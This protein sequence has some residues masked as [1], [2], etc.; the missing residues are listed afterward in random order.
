MFAEK[1]L[2]T[3]FGLGQFCDPKFIEMIGTV[4]GW[5]AVWLDQEHA[6]L[7]IEQISHAARAAKVV[8]LDCFVRLAPTDYAT[9]MRPLEV[10][11]Y[12]IMAAQVR[13]T[14]Q[15][16]QVIEWA[17]FYP[18]GMRGVNSSGVDGA[19]G[20]VPMADYM[21]QA[22]DETYVIIQI[23]HK[24]A[25]ECVEEIAA[26]KHLD[27]LFIGPADLSQSM[28]LPG[29]L[30]HPK[31]IEAIERVAAACKKTGVAWTILPKDAAL[32]KRCVELGC[33]MLSLGTDNVA[34]FRGLRTLHAD[35][36]WLRRG[37]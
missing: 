34:L 28:G 3:A 23:E 1:K 11:A 6:G 20:T 35:F 30:D 13:S 21:K 31:V 8:G 36:E 19:F 25:L 2:A 24:D 26:L 10:G 4:G 29:Q 22:N 16:A 27:A 33:A 5:D 9:V 14:K 32:A 18:Q 37:K 17:K 15:A 12:G 7:T